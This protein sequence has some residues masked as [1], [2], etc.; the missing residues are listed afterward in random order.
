M[1]N[2]PVQLKTPYRYQSHTALKVLLDL[3]IYLDGPTVDELDWLCDY[4]D[5]ICPAADRT[6]FQISDTSPGVT[7]RPSGG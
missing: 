7:S 5:S 4:Y 1:T 6:A 3:T 2:L